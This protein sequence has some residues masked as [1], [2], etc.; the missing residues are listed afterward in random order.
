[1][2][3]KRCRHV[4]SENYRTLAARSLLEEGDAEGF[5]RLM[6]DSHASLRDE[7]EVSC[8]ELD[9]LVGIAMSV[10]GTLGSRM[11]GGGFGGSSVS[12]VRSGRLEQFQDCVQREYVR[13]TNLSPTIRVVEAADGAREI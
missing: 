8:A 5:G 3:A 13:A 9:L 2:I 4:V 7:Y 6:L 11:T 1:V 10:E 12:L